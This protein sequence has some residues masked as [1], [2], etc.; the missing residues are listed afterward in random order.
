MGRN[1]KY[2]RDEV[3]DTAMRL[4]W[5]R[6]YQATSIAEISQTTGLNTASMYKEFGD[7]DGLF[8][9]ALRHYRGHVLAPRF[10]ILI[11][12]PN[13]RGVEAFLNSVADGAAKAEYRGCLMMNHLAQK[14][15]ISADAADMIDEVCAAIEGLLE[16]AL[17]NAQ[18]AGDLPPDKDPADLASYVMCCVHGFVLYGRHQDKKHFIPSIYETVLQALRA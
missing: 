18:S 5:Q 9:G 15:A 17:S 7:K 6:G 13:L 12:Q 16:A 3:L 2:D 1:R 10:E 11:D 14:H 4:F 8:E